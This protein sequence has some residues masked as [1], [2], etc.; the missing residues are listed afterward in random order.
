MSIEKLLEHRMKGGTVTLERER[1]QQDTLLHFTVDM[2]I[3]YSAQCIFEQLLLAMTDSDKSWIWPVEYEYSPERPAGG[4][5]EGCSFKM[6]YKVPRFDKPEIPSKAV[7]YTYTLAQYRP[8]DCLFE[9]RSVDHPLQGGAVVQTVPL[10]DNSCRLLWQ[11]AYRQDV[12]QAVVV[13]SLRRYIPFFYDK[14]AQRIAAGP[15][16]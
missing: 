6:T 15:P 1:R 11:G 8:A 9:Y 10:D 7:T 12:E 4:I 5:R 13:E 16:A 3:D 2:V 14:I